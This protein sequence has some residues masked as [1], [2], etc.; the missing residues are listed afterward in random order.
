MHIAAFA[1]V[2]LVLCAPPEAVRL[3]AAGEEKIVGRDFFGAFIDF[4]KALRLDEGFAQGWHGRGL[5]RAELGD[6]EGGI[7][8]CS[9]AIELDGNDPNGFN[10]RGIA[11]SVAGDFD[12][13]IEDYDR[14]LAL[15]PEAATIVL[16]NRGNARVRK[17]DFDGAIRDFEKALA[18]GRELDVIH[19]NLGAAWQLKG[20]EAR[21]LEHFGKAIEAN[22]KNGAS[23][24]N[25][26]NLRADRGELRDALSDLRKA[27]QLEGAVPF[28]TARYRIWL[29]SQQLGE[30]PA[31]DKELREW[32]ASESRIKD[33]RA[34]SLAAFLV[35]DVPEDRIEE[36]L[37]AFGDAEK[38]ELEE[39][40]AAVATHT[41]ALRRT[42]SLHAAGA[43][44]QADLDGAEL[45]ALVAELRR[46]SIQRRLDA[47][48]GELVC[49]ALFLAGGKRVLKGE[50]EAAK[51]LF[52]KCAGM[53][54]L[55]AARVSAARELRRLSR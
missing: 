53:N 16:A 25:R 48:T 12:G 1:L 42:R 13:A 55:S 49:E 38:A 52:E 19:G 9:R 5:A 2:S 24:L 40:V 39:A 33:S 22:P 26:G 43:A 21:A 31:A 10:R 34:A 17:R 45:A 8:D 28:R 14:A 27:V 6:T 3:A 41:Q 32:M 23:W 37:G 54:V 35:G 47:R 29:V 11:R 51:A 4:T 30:G 15:R 44:T 36:L 46:D 7:A 20:D 50:M 18:G